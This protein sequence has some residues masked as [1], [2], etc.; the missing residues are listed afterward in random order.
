MDNVI[1]ID[2][3][4]P[5]KIILSETHISWNSR[6][7]RL[8]FPWIDIIGS[9]LGLSLKYL[10]IMVYNRKKDKFKIYRL[11]HS[12]HKAAEE[13]VEKINGFTAVKNR[14]YAVFLNPISG[15]NKSSEIFNDLLE[16]ILDYSESLY[17][18]FQITSSDYFET[19]NLL[20]LS[21]FT[22]IIV[23]GGDGTLHLLLSA[24]YSQENLISKFN[25]SIIPTG[26]QNALAAELYGKS[27]NSA[28]LS[29][30]KGNVSICDLIKVTL[31]NKKIIAASAVAWGLISDI[32]EEA[33]RYR[34]FKTWRYGITTF[35]RIFK[36]WNSYKCEISLENK[37]ETGEFLC[38]LIG[39]HTSK[40]F[41]GNDIAFPRADIKD[42]LLDIE[43]VDFLGKW[44]AIKFFKKMSNFGMHVNSK[45]N[46]YSKDKSVVITPQSHFLFNVDGEIYKSESLKAEVLGNSIKYLVI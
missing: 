23:L 9:R 19:L 25:F 44:K 39:N 10:T 4:T 40:S 33:S 22:D 26:S 34:S 37:K 43:I 12:T 17:T 16:N 8:T 14:N 5:S 28:L 20:D 6:K 45:K 42:G 13:L 24:L 21:E 1:W 18:V 31:D 38:V 27:L 46:H 32:A 41:I 29:T 35:F 3:E 11:R 2:S 15:S 30:V 7:S 36:P